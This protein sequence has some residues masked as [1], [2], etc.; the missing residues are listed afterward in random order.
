MDMID[1]IRVLERHGW[2]HSEDGSGRIAEIEKS[3]PLGEDMVFGIPDDK[4]VPDE[5]RERARRFDPNGHVAA[6][7]RNPLP[8]QPSDIRA[9]CDDADAIK[10]ML[11]DLD[12][13][14]RAVS[15]PAPGPVTAIA[16]KRVL[17]DYDCGVC[18]GMWVIDSN[19][20]DRIATALNDHLTQPRE[21]DRR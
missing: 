1:I 5:V 7:V 21:G 10:A 12:K 16:L 14:L 15:K 9:L 13:A 3:S 20:V 19:D 8:G 17:R 2:A 6:L 18:G 11:E 4:T